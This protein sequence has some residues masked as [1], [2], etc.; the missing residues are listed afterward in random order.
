M[1]TFRV[2]GEPYQAG[3]EAG[4]IIFKK[5]IPVLF[6]IPVLP[7]STKRRKGNVAMLLVE[8]SARV[9]DRWHKNAG[10]QDGH[11]FPKAPLLPEA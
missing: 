3:T 6:Q 4:T 5:T 1:T 7:R 11:C 2:Y 8:R 10:S 9:L